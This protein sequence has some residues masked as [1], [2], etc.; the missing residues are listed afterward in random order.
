MSKNSPALVAANP[1]ALADYVG[2]LRADIANLNEQLKGAQ[3]LLEQ[4]VGEGGEAEGELFRVKVV[5][6][7]RVTVAWRKVAEKLEPSAQL[8]AAHTSKSHV[9]SFRVSARK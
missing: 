2:A 4:M 5:G 9:V 3:A 1:S 7:D 6:S 8:V